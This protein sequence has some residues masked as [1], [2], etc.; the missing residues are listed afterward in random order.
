MNIEEK[1]WSF[2]YSK[3]GNSFGTAGVMGNLYAE[4]ALNPENLE[5]AYEK[6]LG[7]NDA[8]YTAAV[9]SGKYT[10]FAGDSAGYGIAQWT[11]GPRK[12]KFL[13]YAKEQGKSIGDLNMQLG[14]LWKELT[15]DYPGVVSV[16]R[17]ASSVRAASDKVL[18]DFE[19]PAD[20]SDA[21]RARRAKFGQSYYDKY[22]FSAKPSGGMTEENLR[23]LVVNTI[24]AWLGSYMGSTGHKEIL[25][26]YNNYK[27]LARGYV[28]KQTDAY[29]ATT[30][31]AAWIKAGIASHTGT[32]CGVEEFTN[33]AKAR[34]IW[35]E[36]DAYIPKLGDACVYDWQ[37]DGKGDCIGNADHIGIVSAVFQ[38]QGYFQVIEGN[39]SGGKVGTRMMRFNGQ[40][41]RGFICPKYNE[42][43]TAGKDEEE[44][45]M[46]KIYADV[47]DLPYDRWK[48][49]IQELLDLGCVDGGTPREKNATDI[50]LSEDT[51]KAIVI[52]KDYFD[53]KYGK[54][55]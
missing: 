19:R 29:C 15:E 18:L 40:Y 42:L 37:D 28:V 14:F 1:I 39:M 38:S 23:L 49:E 35:V 34:G 11:W 44:N 10:N 27:P 45:E 31:S 9:D 47:K 30:V 41:I 12:K 4:S 21:V 22:A 7:Y 55:G 5:N 43:A 8:S 26:I 24:A 2:L 13:A 17:S 20:Q 16:L 25:S 50:N 54:E 6:R 53:K 46:A 48:K 52:M 3:I 33:V 36:N 51:V 32:E